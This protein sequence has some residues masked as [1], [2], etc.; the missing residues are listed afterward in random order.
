MPPL[1][2]DFRVFCG[3]ASLLILGMF[4]LTW[5]GTM[6]KQESDRNPVHPVNPVIL[7]KRLFR[8]SLSPIL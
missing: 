8:P 3:Q 2:V 7:T 4:T 6:E 1:F 5:N